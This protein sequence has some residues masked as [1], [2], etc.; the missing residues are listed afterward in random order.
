MIIDGRDHRLTICK[1]CARAV[2]ADVAFPAFLRTASYPWGKKEAATRRP[3]FLRICG[4][5]CEACEQLG[6]R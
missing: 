1:G 6:P 4:S 3:D 2:Q 5:E